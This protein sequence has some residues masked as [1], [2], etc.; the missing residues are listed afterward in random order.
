MRGGNER[1]TRFAKDTVLYSG[2]YFPG[3]PNPNVFQHK[4]LHTQLRGFTF[5]YDA[6]QVLLATHERPSHVR[7]LYQRESGRLPID[8]G[9]IY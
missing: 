7:A 3:V 9:C 8:W 4:P 2:W 6:E 5:Q 1:H